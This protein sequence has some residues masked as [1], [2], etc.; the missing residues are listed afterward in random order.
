MT[1]KLDQPRI[2]ALEQAINA[3]AK[4]KH[5]FHRELTPDFVAELYV[6]R[7]LNLQLRD[8]P[9][10]KGYDAIGEDGKRYEIK[11][12]NA[13]NV[14]LNGYDFDFVVLVNLD[15]NYQLFGMWKMGVETARKIF[16]WRGDKFRK[17]QT[18]QVKFKQNAERIR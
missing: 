11:E 14:D 18:T 3:M 8:G 13:Q 9:N 16:V 5:A 7:E 6:A 1:I 15:D 4:F 12:R 17:F 10:E 2:Q